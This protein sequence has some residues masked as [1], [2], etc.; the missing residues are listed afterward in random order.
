MQI[1]NFNL[2]VYGLLIIDN[3]ILITDENRGGMHMTKFPGGGLE[4]G[5]GLRDCLKREFIEELELE[6][7]VGDL[8]YTNDFLQVSAFKPSDQLHSFYYFVSAEKEVEIV[9]KTG[10]PAAGEQ[11]FRWL[12]VDKLNPLE[13]TFPI[14]RVVV[15]RLKL[16]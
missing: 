4:K 1:T 12:E 2:R 9:T 3:Q 6:V 10:M 14:D 11:Y 5:E 7:S 15:E 16:A 8:F 13:F